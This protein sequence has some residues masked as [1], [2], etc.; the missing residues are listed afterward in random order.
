MHEPVVLANNEA[1][2]KLTW[3]EINSK[4]TAKR[5]ERKRKPNEIDRHDKRH[6]IISRARHGKKERKKERKKAK[7]A[8]VYPSIP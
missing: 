2:L 3:R 4:F 1:Q 6:A 8:V 7:E 5:K